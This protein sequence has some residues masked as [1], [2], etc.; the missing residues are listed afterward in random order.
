[1][2]KGEGVREPFIRLEAVTKDCPMGQVTAHAWRRLDLGIA[3]GMFHTEDARQV[4][5]TLMA[6]VEGTLVRRAVNP[7]MMTLQVQLE[8]GIRPLLDGLTVSGKV[9]E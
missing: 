1:M 2:R 8:L 7:R 4:A 3:P 6:I 5:A 9:S